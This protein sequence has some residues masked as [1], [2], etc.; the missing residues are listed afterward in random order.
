MGLV[1][2]NGNRTG[3]Q[4]KAG[5]DRPFTAA[6][7]GC[8]LD[9]GDKNGRRTLWD[10]FVK[11]ET[12]MWFFVTPVLPGIPRQAYRGILRPLASE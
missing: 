6:F 12:R 7:L 4:V 5:L 10:A 2:Q 11:K 9:G 8:R 1:K 3:S